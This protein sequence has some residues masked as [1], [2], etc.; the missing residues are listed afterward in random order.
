VKDI[1]LATLLALNTDGAANTWAVVGSIAAVLVVIVTFLKWVR[2]KIRRTKSDVVAARDSILGREAVVD[3]I[4]G[5]T[6]R[7][8]LPGI[9]VR[10]AN[11]EAQMERLTNAVATIAQSHLHMDS[12][13]RRVTQVEDDVAALKAASAERI[14]GN[15]A[16]ARVFGALDKAITNK[17][18]IDGEVSDE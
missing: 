16:Q 9:G 8:A 18:A 11:N 6:I 4:T 7:E 12:I 13:A 17:G 10:M 3:T 5:E 2:P 1:F 14:T 15:I